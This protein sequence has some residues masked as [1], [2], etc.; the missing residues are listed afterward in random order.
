MDQPPFRMRSGLDTIGSSDSD[1]ILLQDWLRKVEA[2]LLVLERKAWESAIRYARAANRDVVTGEDCHYAAKYE[3]RTFLHAS[4]LDERVKEMYDRLTPKPTHPPRPHARRRS[5]ERERNVCPV[6]AS[7]RGTS[8]SESSDGPTR[9]RTA[10]SSSG[11]ASD[12][13]DHDSRSS[14]SDEN[15]I[16]ETPDP[17]RLGD[18]R[19]DVEFHVMGPD[20][21]EIEDERVPPFTRAPDTDPFARKVHAVVDRWDEWNPTDMIERMLKTNMDAAH[22]KYCEDPRPD[23]VY[24]RRKS[25]QS[26]RRAVQSKR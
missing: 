13:D 25:M 14:E 7:T 22:A 19:S 3:I 26:R 4:D 5:Q 10:V 18:E 12:G 15:E 11:Y 17:P 6:P 23:V 1:D 8:E 16:T 9:Q 20:W 2:V 24:R 21:E